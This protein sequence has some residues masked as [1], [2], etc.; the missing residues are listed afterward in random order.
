MGAHHHVALVVV[1]GFVEVAPDFDTPHAQ[2]GLPASRMLEGLLTNRTV[3]SVIRPLL[4]S[5]VA[6]WVR[7]MRAR[8]LKKAPLLP[9]DL[10]RELTV[11]LR[12]DIAGTAALIGRNL[13]HWL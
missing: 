12:D 10:K 4:P 7:R 3:G 8:N 11:P 13:D 1:H 9:A 2:G 5:G 6:N